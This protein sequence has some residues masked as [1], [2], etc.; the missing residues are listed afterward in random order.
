MEIMEL[1]LNPKQNQV[2]TSHHVNRTCNGVN[3]PNPNLEID[4]A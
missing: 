4:L 3:G 1:A 2:G